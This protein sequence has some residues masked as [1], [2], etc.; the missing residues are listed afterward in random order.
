MWALST[1][2]LGMLLGSKP[3]V[4]NQKGIPYPSAARIDFLKTTAGMIFEKLL[5]IARRDKKCNGR[6]LFGLVVW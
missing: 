4:Q 5:Y 3:P 1:A 2:T 6:F